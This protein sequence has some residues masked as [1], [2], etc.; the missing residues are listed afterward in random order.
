MIRGRST[1][2]HKKATGSWRPSNSDAARARQLSDKVY[3]LPSHDEIPD[4][5]LPLREKGL[6]KYYELCGR[7]YRQGKLTRAARDAAEQIAVMHQDQFERL[8]AGKRVPA[9]ITQT[10]QRNMSILNLIEE[11]EKLTAKEPDK[12]N[13]FAHAGFPNQRGRRRV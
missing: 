6:L 9:Y 3:A 12:P 10:I 1:D 5:E 2:E 4:P 7:L 13:R 8:Q 11:T